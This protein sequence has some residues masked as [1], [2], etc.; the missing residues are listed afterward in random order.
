MLVFVTLLCVGAVTRAYVALTPGPIEC[1]SEITTNGDVQPDPAMSPDDSTAPVWDTIRQVVVAPMSGGA[2]LTSAVLGMRQC[3]GPPLIVTF[4]WPPRTGGGTTVGDTF[5]TWIPDWTGTAKDR[6]RT[7]NVYA[8]GAGEESFVRFGPDIFTS[9]TDAELLARHETHHLDQWAVFTLGGGPLAFP[10]SYYTDTAFFPISRNHFERAAGL[11]DGNY[12]IPDSYG[13][14]PVWPLVA[15]IGL[16]LVILLRTRLRLLSRMLV[17]GREQRRR[18]L[19][20]RCPRHSTGWFRP[21]RKPQTP[22]P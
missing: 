18:H 8:F 16:V 14:D 22:G 2:L 20:D 5:V 13:P 7:T 12:P 3:A 10:V 9:T 15:A 19:P 11:S 4:W 6:Q 17:G 1:R 21:V